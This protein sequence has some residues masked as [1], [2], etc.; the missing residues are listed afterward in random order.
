MTSAELGPAIRVAIIPHVSTHSGGQARV[1]VTWSEEAIFIKS[2]TGYAWSDEPGGLAISADTEQAQKDCYKTG[3]RSGRLGAIAA[4][5]RT[6]AAGILP[7]EII[8]S[9]YYKLTTAQSTNSLNC[10]WRGDRKKGK[11]GKSS[12][13]SEFHVDRLVEVL[14][15]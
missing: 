3:C 15:H 6:S 2:P 13:G 14:E 9:D 10:S 7:L 1:C 8:R 11:S 4:L 12:D 5:Q